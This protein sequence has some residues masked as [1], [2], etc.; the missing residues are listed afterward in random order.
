MD[1]FDQSEPDHRR[2]HARRQCRA[3]MQRTIGQIGD[4]VGRF[5][6]RHDGAVA[7]C[8]R[9]FLVGD[10][11]AAFGGEP[12]D[13]QVLQ[14]AA[15][16]GIGEVAGPTIGDRGS[17]F[18]ALGGAGEAQEHGG[19]VCSAFGRVPPPVLEMAALAGARVE[20]RPQTV[21][22]LGRGGGGHPKLAEQSVA[23]LELCFLLEG[24]V[25]R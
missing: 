18:F 19:C 8:D 1:L 14:L 2:R 17:L 6:Q 15:I 7:K 5:A 11:H 13:G 23:E 25:G 20:Q 22:R 12:G 16:D 10:C 9:L 24:D 4:G 21:G 3:R